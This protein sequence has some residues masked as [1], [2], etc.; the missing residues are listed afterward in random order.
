MNWVEHRVACLVSAAVVFP[1]SLIDFSDR[2]Y[3]SRD[4]AL[5]AFVAPSVQVAPSVLSPTIIMEDLTKWVGQDRASQ[6]KPRV[7]ILQGIFYAGSAPRAALSLVAEDGRPTERTRVSSGDVVEGW[8]VES[9]DSKR[10]LLKRDAETR[11]L[12]LFKRR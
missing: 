6:V 8:K 2:I 3:V 10:V 12:I 7:I 1:L 9:I 11:E 4:R 5:R